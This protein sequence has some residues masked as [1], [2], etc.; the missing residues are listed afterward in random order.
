LNSDA[1]LAALLALDSATDGVWHPEETDGTA[2]PRRMKPVAIKSM[3]ENGDG[4]A[5][6]QTKYETWHRNTARTDCAI[7]MRQWASN[8]ALRKLCTNYL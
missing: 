4:H 7:L 5:K 2:T 1:G 6:P 8:N 3:F